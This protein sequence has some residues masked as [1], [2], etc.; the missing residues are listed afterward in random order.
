[1]HRLS[2]SATPGA[3]ASNASAKERTG[4]SP[5]TRLACLA[6]F[7]NTLGDAMAILSGAKLTR[8]WS[9]SA[10][11]LRSAIKN[12]RGISGK[13]SWSCDFWCC[14]FSASSLAIACARQKTT[15]WV[16]E[17]VTVES[18]I[19]CSE[20]RQLFAYLAFQ[21]FFRRWRCVTRCVTRSSRR[22]AS[23]GVKQLRIGPYLR[24]ERKEII[25]VVPAIRIVKHASGGYF[26]IGQN[27]VEFSSELC[28][29]DVVAN[30][31]VFLLLALLAVVVFA[32]IGSGGG[33]SSAATTLV[34]VINVSSSFFSVNDASVSTLT[35]SR[36]RTP[37]KPMAHVFGKSSQLRIGK[38]HSMIG[39]SSARMPVA[40][41]HI[42]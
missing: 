29:R 26:R 32:A 22:L 4:L 8:S 40:S 7:Q 14:V 20:P 10:T 39:F 28:I 36:F 35:K 5:P 18:S 16:I 9:F 37:S 34:A 17:L 25:V 24:V 42:R 31:V 27:T 1:M 33:I 41:K 11:I 38:P 21:S 30:V 13:T 15:G 6:T 12:G 23:L 2:Q 3:N 19:G